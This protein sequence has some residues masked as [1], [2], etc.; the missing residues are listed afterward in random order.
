MTQFNSEKIASYIVNW[1]VDYLEEAPLDG[2][3]VGVSGGVDSAVVATLCAQTRKKVLLLNMP[4]LQSSAEY[5]RAKEQIHH[6]EVSYENVSSLEIDLTSTFITF[7]NAL[8]ESVGSNDLSMANARARIRMTTLY[9]I[10]QE[11]YCLVVGTGNKVEDFGIGFFTKYG[12]GGVDINPIADLLKS[13]VYKLARHLNVCKSIIEAK[14]TDGLWGDNRNDE[15]QIGASY[16][17]LEFAMNYKGAY[18]DLSGRQKEIYDIYKRYNTMNQ[19]KM[20]PIPYC[21]LSEV[22]S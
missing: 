21:D 17:E 19:H 4:I 10:G 5:E 14:P 2:F 11:H 9:A 13:E 16:D 3:I 7:K 1:L 18:D 15:D 20:K 8:P 22:K 6:L 12:D